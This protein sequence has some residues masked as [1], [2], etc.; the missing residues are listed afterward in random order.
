M[1]TARLRQETQAA[2]LLTED[3]VPLMRQDLTLSL[4][5]QVLQGFYCVARAWDAWAE[6][7]APT[8]LRAMLRE[9][10]HASLLAD[11]LHA[12]GGEIPLETAVPYETLR[13][14]AVKGGARSVFLGRMYVMEGSTL[15]GQMLARHVED[16]LK[17]APGK[18][19]SYFLGYGSQ[20][21][22]RWRE[23]K[24]LLEVLP[25]EEAD[26]VIASANQM[27][28]FFGDTMM[29]HVIARA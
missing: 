26:T 18:G 15:G 17:L 7:N 2:H 3:T 10:R 23:F 29:P 8:D 20:T 1:D 19:D 9:R 24:Q 16:R 28:G 25:E 14:S 6:A 27:F 21:G 12:V 5:A 13:Q 4:Y 11:D 22:Q